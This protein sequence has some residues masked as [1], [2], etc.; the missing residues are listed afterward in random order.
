MNPRF[1][2]AGITGG[3][4]SPFTAALRLFAVLLLSLT[5]GLG[6]AWAA[7]VRLDVDNDRSSAVVVEVDRAPVGTVPARARQVLSAQPGTREVLVRAASGE[8]LYRAWHRTVSGEVVRLSLPAIDAPIR[9]DNPLDRP[10]TLLVDGVQR[11]T[12]GPWATVSLDLA[13]GRRTLQL[14]LDG[15]TLVSETMTVSA[16]C[17]ALAWSP[18]P[19][20]VGDLVVD[21]PLPIAV[22]L[23]LPS[24]KEQVVAAY[25]QARFIGL[26]EGRLVV[27]ARRAD[28]GEL[29]EGLRVQVWA[30]DAVAA[31]VAPPRTGILELKNLR[32]RGMVTVEVDGVRR[33]VLAPQ[34]AERIELSPGTRRLLLRDAYG[35]EI[36]RYQVVVDRYDVRSVEVGGRGPHERPGGGVSHNSHHRR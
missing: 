10:V 29:I 27:E 7:A 20:R 2:P 1:V 32:G 24:G 36:D 5:V 12:L 18:D 33:V 30:F 4:L 19:P 15:R 31:A 16:S 13:F 34:D 14:Q 26:P 23:R 28:G 6:P 35:R 11:A 3:A 17:G 21:N 8:V 9:V 22:R 25:G